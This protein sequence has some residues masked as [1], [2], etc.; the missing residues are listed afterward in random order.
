M[1]QI[2]PHIEVLLIRAGWL[3]FCFT[4]FGSFSLFS[5]IDLLT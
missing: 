2:F 1:R 3:G 5:E 4:S